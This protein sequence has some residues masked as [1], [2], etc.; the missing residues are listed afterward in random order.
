MSENHV[1]TW[2]DGSVITESA[3]V[4]IMATIRG[5]PRALM[6]TRLEVGSSFLHYVGR[7][8]SED[9][10][11]IR[12]IREAF[13]ARLAAKYPGAGPVETSA[14]ASLV[15]EGFGPP[16]A[17][18]GRLSAY[19]YEHLEVPCLAREV[20]AARK[21]LDAAFVAQLKTAAMERSREVRE[22]A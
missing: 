20:E 6:T 16:R 5:V 9:C 17:D 10:Y 13:A 22:A 7:A 18:G 11:G 3:T 15:Y 21:R 14:R 12:T 1:Y 19:V 2:D 4:T 8:A